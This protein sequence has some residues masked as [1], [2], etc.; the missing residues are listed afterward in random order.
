[1]KIIYAYKDVYGTYIHHGTRYTEHS[2]MSG[3]MDAGWSLKQAIAFDFAHSVESGEQY[4]VEKN[5][6][7]SGPFTKE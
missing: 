6:K 3:T 4:M 7:L 2:G 5:G 1:M